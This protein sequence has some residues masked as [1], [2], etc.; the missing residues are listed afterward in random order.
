[1]SRLLQ[2]RD[3]PVYRDV[4]SYAFHAAW[5]DRRYWPLAFLS[6]FLLTAGS[7]DVLWKAVL[8][9]QQQSA[10][11][12]S[13]TNQLRIDAIFRSS[14]GLQA[15]LMIA[16]LFI[17]VAALSAVAQGGL[18]YALGGV[19]RGKRPTLRQAFRAGANAFWP[20]AALNALMVAT[21]WILRFF[22][23]LPLFFALQ[24]TTF[25]TWILYVVSFPV[26]IALSFV[27]S[28]VHI[29][30]LNAMVLQGA[31]VAEAVARGYDI[32]KKH[33]VIA[34][35]T[36][37]LLLLIAF[38]A[39]LAAIGIFFLLMIPFF[40]AAIFAGALHSNALLAATLGVLFAFFLCTLF[41]LASSV[42][43]FQYAAWTYLYRRLGEG[44]AVPK[45]H[46]WIRA[47]SGS[48]AVPT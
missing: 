33:W 4:L 18:V 17:A 6:S 8:S 25:I 36:T 37:G 34:L 32:F 46:R 43:Q 3:A 11:L 27:V 47:L 41:V 24:H 2:R 48:T 14:Y 29:F 22:I 23:T 20:I 40:G 38:A 31:P 42:I 35:E 13:P 16:I 28:I 1:M 45:L 5:K 10:A 15:I 21:L 26:F 44:G 39:S 30:A 9:I 19:R 12:V 7:Y